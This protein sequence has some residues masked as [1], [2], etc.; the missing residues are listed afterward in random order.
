MECFV[1][2]SIPKSQMLQ[3][4]SLNILYFWNKALHNEQGLFG[5][6]IMSLGLNLDLWR[7]CTEFPQRLKVSEGSFC[8]GNTA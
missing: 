5:G 1:Y 6:K 4:T 3:A 2:K 8:G 7:K